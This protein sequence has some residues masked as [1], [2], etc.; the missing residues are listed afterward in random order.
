M[1]RDA[2]RQA[3]D[4]AAS[5]REARGRSSVAMLGRKDLGEEGA[6]GASAAA[7]AAGDAA[8]R[9]LQA[10]AAAWAQLPCEGLPCMQCA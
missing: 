1:S 3:A 9:I 8:N 4:L 10:C 7:A 5:M 2:P 6:P